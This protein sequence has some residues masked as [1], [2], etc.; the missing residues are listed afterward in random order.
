MSVR[1][2]EQEQANKDAIR[3]AF[4]EWTA[5]NRSGENRAGTPRAVAI[6]GVVEAW[7]RDGGADACVREV[8]PQ[9]AATSTSVH[10]ANSPSTPRRASRA[11]RR[12]MSWRLGIPAENSLCALS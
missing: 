6:S 8:A 5:G 10:D 1:N 9:A 2:L 3:A 7:L 12:M 4:D 11:S